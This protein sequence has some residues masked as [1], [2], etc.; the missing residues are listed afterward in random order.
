[1]SAAPRLLLRGR[2]I[3]PAR[4]IAE[5][6]VLVE[7]GRVSWVRPGRIDVAGVELIDGPGQVITPGFIDLQVNGFAGN[8]AAA[9]TASISSIAAALPRV[10]RPLRAFDRLRPLVPRPHR[11]HRQSHQPRHRRSAPSS[12]V[13]R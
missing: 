11:R 6:S 10:H 13:P 2:V 3:T 1:M 12:G 5:G 8:D 4:D 7:N 9:G